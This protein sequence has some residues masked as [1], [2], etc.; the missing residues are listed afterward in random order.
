MFLKS[1][2]LEI[3]SSKEKIESRRKNGDVVGEGEIRTGFD[4]GNS[5][6]GTVER[7][8]DVLGKGDIRTG[9]DEGNSPGG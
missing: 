9:Y 8:D 4:E 1:S 6:G 7:N 2:G 5:L 3:C